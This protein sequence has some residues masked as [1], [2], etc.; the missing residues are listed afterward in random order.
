MIM[1]ERAWR[2]LIS[3]KK[4]KLSEIP[5]FALLLAGSVLYGA[6]GVF[7]ALLFAL[8]ILKPSGV[9]AKVVSIGNITAGGT[10]KTPFTEELAKRFC[11]AEKKV[12]IVAKGYKRKKINKTDAVSDGA[13]LLLDELHAGDEAF[14]L[15]RAVEGAA[16]VVSD[17]KIKG[18][19]YGVF[20]FRPDVVILD[21]GFQKRRHI[22]EASQVV[23]VDC[24]NPFGYGRLLPA[25][26]LRESPSALKYA[27]AVVLTNVN[28]AGGP[29]A[30]EKI[31]EAVL[32]RAKN[33]KIFEAEHQPKHYYNIFTGERQGTGYFSGKRAVLF[34][35]LG[36][37]AGFERTV[38]SLGVNPAV[39][40]RF[41]DHHRL[42]KKETEAI[43]RL[44]E[45]TKAD[46][47]ITTE[48]DEV[49]FVKKNYPLK[50][51]W[52]LKI[53]MLIKNIKELEKRLKVQ[54]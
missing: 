51:I 17:D 41:K 15:A 52:V 3:R 33:A 48:K 32:N 14:M 1:N 28:I 9:K 27:D 4:K 37:P 13:A 44:S 53:S 26:T 25:G 39:S 21:D 12:L 31:K 49:K 10:G 38:K 18:I 6:A 8:K 45:G 40:L 5:V 24:L 19:E 22:P 30:V 47:V 11:K 43:A 29:E 23:L 46:A 20:R 36:N 2:E 50:D 42:S 7:K 34:S 54:L 16:V 35:S